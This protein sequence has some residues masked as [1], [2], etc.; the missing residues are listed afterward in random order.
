MP[1][2]HIGAL[3]GCRLARGLAAPLAILG[4]AMY[5]C[6]AHISTNIINMEIMNN[7]P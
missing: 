4:I 2:S 7:E 3:T 6:T 1:G 5:T